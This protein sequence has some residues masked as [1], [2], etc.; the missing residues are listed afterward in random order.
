V[1]G[2]SRRSRL[3]PALLALACVVLAAIALRVSEPPEFQV[4]RGSLQE[5]VRLNEGDVSVADVR[6]GDTVVEDG[7]TRF[8][9][10]GMF[11]VVRISGAATGRDTLR[12]TAF[13]LLSGDRVYEPFANLSSVTSPPGFVT[14]KD[15]VFEVDP[16]RIDGLTLELW[17]EEIVSGY[18]QRLQIPLGVTPRTADAW[19]G[20][21]HA[22]V[23]DP[24]TNG[25]TRAVP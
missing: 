18:Q 14:A 21:A 22:S 6:I 1:T 10:P 3:L 13:R 8:R 19:R 15:L 4:V 20:R 25:T 16:G 12:L 23:T 9:T 11:V 17:P 7:Q 24:D 2:R 5:Q